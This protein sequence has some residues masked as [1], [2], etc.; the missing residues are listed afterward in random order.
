[1][2]SVRCGIFASRLP[3]GTWRAGSRLVAFLER[4]CHLP[5]NDSDVR[6]SAGPAL[7]PKKTRAPRSSPTPLKANRW[8]SDFAEFQCVGRILLQLCSQA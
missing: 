7:A 4:H 6:R 5:T 3:F 1:M 2:I 8:R